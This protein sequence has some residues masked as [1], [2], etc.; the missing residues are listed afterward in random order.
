MQSFFCLRTFG[1]MLA[2]SMLVNA[3]VLADDPAAEPLPPEEMMIEMGG[4]IYTLGY[5]IT[6]NGWN[7]YPTRPTRSE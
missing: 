3:Q 6:L 2:A 5:D 4:N 7:S 1:F